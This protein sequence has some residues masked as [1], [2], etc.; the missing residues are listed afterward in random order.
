MNILITSPHQ[1]RFDTDTL[2]NMVEYAY[3][4]GFG[5]VSGAFVEDEVEEFFNVKLDYDED[6]EQYIIHFK[7]DQDL[8][9]FKLKYS[10][11]L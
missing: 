9:L 7:T 1:F 2:E 8:M 11:A 4:N 3:R 10:E 5:P 6:K